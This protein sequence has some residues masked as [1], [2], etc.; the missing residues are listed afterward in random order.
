[1]EQAGYMIKMRKTQKT[2]RDGEKV[3]LFYTILCFP[4]K[5]IKVYV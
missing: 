3:V 5:R 1:M 4:Y 2:E